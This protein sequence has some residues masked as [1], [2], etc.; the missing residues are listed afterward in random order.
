MPNLNN[1]VN[2]LYQDSSTGQPVPVTQATPLPVTGGTGAGF[3]IDATSSDGGLASTYRLLSSAASTNGTNVKASAG[4]IY[5]LAGRNN[6]AS[7]RYLKLYDKATAPTVG[8]DTPFYTLEIP[9][10]SVFSLDWEDIGRYCTLGIG[11]GLTTA[12][13]D[14][15]TAAVSA[16]DITSLNIDYA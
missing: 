3:S 12:Q 8:T 1:P 10:N 5:Q 14:N 13:A 6:N 15:S 4:R 7:T 9:G 11:F 16:G 2:V